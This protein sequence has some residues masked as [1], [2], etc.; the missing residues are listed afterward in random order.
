M[1]SKDVMFVCSSWACRFIFVVCFV[2]FFFKL[3]TKSSSCVLDKY[4]SFTM[5]RKHQLK[6]CS[7]NDPDNVDGRSS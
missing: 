3:E 2:D 6:N 7:L 5:V 1:L 4:I